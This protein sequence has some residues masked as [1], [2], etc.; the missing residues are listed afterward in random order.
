M[1]RPRLHFVAR[2]AVAGLVILTAAGVWQLRPFREYPGVEYEQFP[3]PKDY[4]EKTEWVFARLMY[5]AAGG[6]GYRGNANWK[7][8]AAKCHRL[9]RGPV[10]LRGFGHG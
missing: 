8:G 1:N 3:L 6:W 5:P 9:V 2:A 7:Q 10:M 4:Q